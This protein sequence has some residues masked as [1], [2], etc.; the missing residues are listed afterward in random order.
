MKNYVRKI[1]ACI[2]DTHGGNSLGLRMPDTKLQN[3]TDGDQRNLTECQI[4]LYGIYES[5]RQKIIDLAEDDEV[6]VIHTGDVCQ[7]NKYT[8]DRETGT[9]A[10]DI[11]IA[12]DNLIPLIDLPNVKTVRLAKGTAAHN[13][14]NGSAEILVAELLSMKYP[15]KSI[16]ATNHSLLDLSGFAVDV[17][18]HGLGLGRRI[19]LK[20]NEA[21]FYLRDIM[22]KEIS[23]GNIPCNLYLRGHIHD[24]VKEVIWMGYGED[25]YESMIVSIPSMC[26]LGQFGTQVTRSAFLITN[27]LVAFEII[28]NKILNVYRLFQTIDIRTKE[29]I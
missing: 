7:G 27:G 24:F 22:M 23:I 8:D 21:R 11:I 13:F 14:G 15:D 26:M 29:C 3:D 12:R 2:S 17:A 16:K 18:H 10:D 28:N 4:H 6:V 19:W 1:I 9:I 5:A 25:E 20:G